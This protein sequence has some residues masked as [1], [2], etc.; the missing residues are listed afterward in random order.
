[1]AKSNRQQY[2]TWEIHLTVASF[3]G[4]M[5]SISACKALIEDMQLGKL[6]TIS[7]VDVLSSTPAK[8]DSNLNTTASSTLRREATNSRSPSVLHRSPTYSPP[9]PASRH[10]PTLPQ[11]PSGPR[12]TSIY[13][14]QSSALCQ[15]QTSDSRLGFQAFPVTDSFAVP[16]TRPHASILIKNEGSSSSGDSRSSSP[17]GRGPILSDI[18]M[19]SV[20]SVVSDRHVSVD[21]SSQGDAEMADFPNKES[22]SP[23]RQQQAF[24]A[25]GVSQTASYAAITKCIS[26]LMQPSGVLQPFI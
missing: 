11:Q 10:E 7:Y 17:A 1:M 21:G 14:Q 3:P 22:S 25:F 12:P 15:D 23:T 26:N 19:A 20:K 13:S 24:L 8:K 4:R 2:K 6:A 9:A 18:D 5:S 16:A